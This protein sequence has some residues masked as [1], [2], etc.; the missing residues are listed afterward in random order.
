MVESLKQGKLSKEQI[1]A[2]EGG[3]DED[4]F[5]LLKDGSFYDPLGYYFNKDG[6]DET[7]G[8]YNDSG[9]YIKA[10]TIP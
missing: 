6:F 4:G 5:Y 7:G 10:P 3:Y 9:V 8:R 2:L 1:E